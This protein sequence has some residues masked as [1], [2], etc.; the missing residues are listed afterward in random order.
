MYGLFYTSLLVAMIVLLPEVLG[1][2]PLGLCLVYAWGLGVIVPHLL[3]VTK[4][5][6]ATLIAM[7]AFHLMLAA[8]ICQALGGKRGPLVA[9]TAVL[10]MSF[11]VPAVINEPGTGYPSRF[12]GFLHQASWVF[13]HLEAALIGIGLSAGLAAVLPKPGFGVVFGSRVLRLGSIV[14]CVSVLTWLSAATVN[15]AKLIT[16]KNKADLACFEIGAFARR[17]LPVNAVFLC[18]EAIGG[19]HLTLMF[20]SG[21]SSYALAR[22]AVEEQCHQ[23]VHAQGTP[24]LVSARTLPL[25]RVYASSDGARFV[26]L[27]RMNFT[28]SSPFNKTVP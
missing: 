8:F 3:A 26:Y 25:P 23:I 22:G 17:E 19:E 7:P 27:W 11:L 6:S 28:S 10:A 4:T 14:F 21:H 20:Y 13:V 5:P 2:R 9:L 16:D 24:Y 15:S 18:E 12:L 1:K